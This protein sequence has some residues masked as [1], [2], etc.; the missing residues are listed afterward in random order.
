MPYLHAQRPDLP[1]AWY[2]IYN[3]SCVGRLAYP[4]E[5]DFWVYRR[6][7]REG[8]EELDGA[9]AEDT[10]SL[11]DNHFHF[12]LQQICAGAITKLFRS[13]G[14]RYAYYYRKQHGGYGHLWQSSLQ[15]LL[16]RDDK[17]VARTRLYI[18]N[19]PIKK[20]LVNWQ[21]VGHVI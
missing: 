1:N 15:G 12:L 11:L 10:F 2:H 5:K 9:C 7:L 4:T 21:H 13:V 20:G 16:L 19:N 17:D 3:R 14:A 18:L 6:Y 8:I